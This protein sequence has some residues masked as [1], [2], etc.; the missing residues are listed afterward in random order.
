[1]S[2][3]NQAI[4]I[5]LAHEGTYNDVKGDAGG[6]T[7]WGVSLRLAQRLGI[8]LC[9]VNHDGQVTKE[10]IRLM[11]REQ[12]V[13]VYRAEWWDR[14]GYE[15]LANQLVATKVFDFAINAGPGVAHACA[16]R[17]AIAQGCKLP[18]TGNLGPMTVGAVNACNAATYL[19][20]YANEMVG[21]YNACVA[22]D[23]TQ[24]K[25]LRGWLARADWPGHILEQ[26]AVA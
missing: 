15:R 5:V 7:N 16:Q 19:W 17:A 9:D 11:T 13:E 20:A 1:L 14:Y 23:L 25:F 3:F 26:R 18:V 24:K 22:H 12:A 2:D 10:D 21:H 4:Q 8:T 6:A